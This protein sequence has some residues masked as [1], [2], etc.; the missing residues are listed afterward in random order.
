VKPLS[1]SKI[2]RFQAAIRSYYRQSARKLP[3][4]STDNPYEILVSEFMLQQT[5][6]HRVVSR[7]HAFLERFPTVYSLAAGPLNDVLRIWSGLGYNRRALAVYRTA[8]VLSKSHG[9]VI[10]DSLEELVKLPGIG[11]A[12]A[13]AICAFAHNQPV[14]FIE[15]N[16]R[17]VFIHFFFKKI[18][19]VHDK[20]I[21]PLVGQT[22]D[23]KDPR[24]WY[25][26]LMDFGSMLK[27][28]AANPNRKSTH[29]KRQGPFE[30]SDRQIRGTIIRCLLTQ[31]PLC[32]DD[33]ARSIGFD[34]NRT[35]LMVQQLLSEGFLVS[36]GNEISV[37]HEA[38]TI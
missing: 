10:P 21:I 3:W 12:T 8:N 1:Q 28:L 35:N 37:A 6:V 11:P 34:E 32:K 7:Y 16:V 13:G 4:R 38:S 15:T 22:L 9:G 24:N 14:V 26:A 30:N 18:H 5:Q 33:L 20:D 31:G 19:S 17:R 27:D 36:K 2:D 29:Y 25:Y 23:R